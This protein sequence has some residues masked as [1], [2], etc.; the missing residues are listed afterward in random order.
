VS[1]LANLRK[2]SIAV[3]AGLLLAGSVL[4]FV[5]FRILQNSEQATTIPLP[6]W[7]SALIVPTPVVSSNPRPYGGVRVIFYKKEAGS[8]SSRL[9]VAEAP[10]GH[11][12]IPDA[13]DA[14][15]T[16]KVGMNL[17]IA[18]D[19]RVKEIRV[20]DG[21]RILAVAAVQAVRL[22]RYA[23]HELNGEAVEAETSVTI[24]FHGQD[25]VSISFPSALRNGLA[26]RAASSQPG[27]TPG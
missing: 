4:A 22:W 11:V 14:H 19:G 16:G 23:H 8:G 20:L 6:R 18:T 21:N 15:L 24:S 27:S 26:L 3:A 5:S 7:T 13:P 17:V 9:Q 2:R 10:Q 25:A 12:I 1:Q